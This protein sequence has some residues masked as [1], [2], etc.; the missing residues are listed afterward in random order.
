MTDKPISYYRSPDARTLTID[1]AR[2]WGKPDHV[3]LSIAPE[4]TALIGAAPFSM[5]VPTAHLLAMIDAE[6]PDAMRAYLRET[7]MHEDR[8]NLRAY[9]EPEQLDAIPE[10][11]SPAD[12]SETMIRKFGR[13]EALLASGNHLIAQASELLDSLAEELDR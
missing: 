7:L 12:L 8:E 3:H 11:D 10:A 13:A 1:A 5:L 2:G 9:L 4:P 6:D